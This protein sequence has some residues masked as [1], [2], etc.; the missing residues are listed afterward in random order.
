MSTT[1]LPVNPSSSRPASPSRDSPPHL[2]RSRSRT[3]SSQPTQPTTEG[4]ELDLQPITEFDGPVDDDELSDAAP[5]EVAVDFPTLRPLGRIGSNTEVLARRSEALAKGARAIHKGFLL[6]GLKLSRTVASEEFPK[7]WELLNR[8]LKDLQQLTLV[9]GDYVYRVQKN[10]YRVL[11]RVLDT[12]RRESEPSFTIEGKTQ[13]ALPQWGNRDDILDAYRPND[14]EI[15]GVCFRVE[16]ENFLMLANKYHDFKTH[17]P[18]ERDAEIAEAASKIYPSPGNVTVK[19][20][21]PSTPPPAA[22]DPP[23]PRGGFDLYGAPRMV[24]TPPRIP[25]HWQSA[26][27]ESTHYPLTR[28]TSVGFNHNP[29]L[30][31]GLPRSKRRISELLE[32]MEPIFERETSGVAPAMEPEEAEQMHRM[33]HQDE[34][35]PYRPARRVSTAN[36]YGGH[37][38]YSAQPTGSVPLQQPYPSAGPP[39]GDPDDSDPDDGP[40]RPPNRVPSGPP[41]RLPSAPPVPSGANI[42]GPGGSME[43]HFEFKLKAEN[44]PKWDGNVDTIVR[45]ILKVNDLARE[46]RTVWRQLGRIAPRR[47]EGEAE[48]WYWS[49]PKT[50]RVT[51]EANWDTLRTAFM[52]YFM[53]RNWLDRQ[54]SRAN[55]AS[56]REAGHGREKPTQYFIRKTDLLNTVYTLSDSEII[57]HVMDGAPTLWNTILTTQLYQDVVEFQSAIRFHEEALMKLDAREKERPYREY[58]NRNSFDPHA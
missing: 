38:A 31:T 1:T 43:A 55:Q 4:A 20:E 18:R 46:S 21:A 40:S 11:E 9:T 53:N 36:I 3:P 30:P 34:N 28:D 33:N 51:I 2:S 27:D 57:L 39:G 13:P 22:I 5:V 41:P 52:T 6:Q 29:V 7:Q 23:R 44:V 10:N 58:D 48:T 14:F 45:W 25:R 56:Y 35:G 37:A 26:Y 50:Y 17:Q 8:T 16:V 15:L 49:L 42:Y 54:R 32:P 24:S 12:M 47:L 19:P